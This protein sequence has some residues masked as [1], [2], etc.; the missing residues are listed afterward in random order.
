MKQL[1]Q[2]EQKKQQTAR[3]SGAGE[4][5]YVVYSRNKDRAKEA[6]AAEPVETNRSS[7]SV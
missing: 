3:V 7:R 4:T 2:Q 5:V 1:V 6:G